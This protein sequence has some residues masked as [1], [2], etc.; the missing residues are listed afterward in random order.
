MLARAL[1]EE[2]EAWSMVD[3]YAA[4]DFSADLRHP[5]IFRAMDRLVKSGTPIDPVTLTEELQRAGEYE[6]AGGFTA[7]S[8]LIDIWIPRDAYSV[9]APGAAL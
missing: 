6:L 7:I 4:D 5:P 9:D 3:R 1:M 8:L 2:H